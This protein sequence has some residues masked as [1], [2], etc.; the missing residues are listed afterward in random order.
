[1][2]NRKINQLKRN[3]KQELDNS[4]LIPSHQSYTAPIF[5]ESTENNQKKNKTKLGIKVVQDKDL[6]GA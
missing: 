4:T 3:P 1:M 5:Q 2:E 6:R